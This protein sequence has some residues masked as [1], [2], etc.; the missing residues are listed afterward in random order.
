[1]AEERTANI[2]INQS[3]GTASKNG[4]TYRLTIPT[5]WAKEMGIEKENRSV[6]LLFEGRKIIIE[7]A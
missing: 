5:T 6:K 4:M 2:I 7:K 3:G 1:M